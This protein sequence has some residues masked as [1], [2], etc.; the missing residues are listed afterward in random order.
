PAARVLDVEDGHYLPMVLS[1]KLHGAAPDGSSQPELDWSESVPILKGLAGEHEHEHEHVPP[2]VARP[3][4]APAPTSPPPKDKG[5][6]G[7]NLLKSPWC[8]G[9]LGAVVAVGI[10]VLVL[11]QTVLNQPEKVTLDGHIAP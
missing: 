9:G 7:A 11:S 10:T 6:L 5:T 4:A 2:P 1:P 3:H 8:W